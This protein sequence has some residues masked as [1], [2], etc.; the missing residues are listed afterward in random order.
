M[1]A[2]SLFGGS[3]EQ[4]LTTETKALLDE[5]LTDTVG[6]TATLTD[7]GGEA[8]L[9]IGTGANGELQGAVVS[10]SVA[11]AAEVNDGVLNVAIEL[12]AGVNFGFE[13]LGELASI[14]EAQ[15][16]FTAQLEQSL[17]ESSA[18][19]AILNHFASLEK[20][21]TT[22]FE[23]LKD[24]G[25]TNLAVRVI[26][27]IDNSGEVAGE[28]D[29]DGSSGQTIVFDGS[30]A[31]ATEALVF[32]LNDIKEGNTLSL[33]GVEN[34]ILTGNGHVVISDDTDAM[35]FGDMFDQHIVGGA[36]NDT[37]V[38]GGGND[39]LEGGS[40]ADI[41]GF[42]GLGNYTIKMDMN[43][44]LAFDFEGLDSLLDLAH[45]MTGVIET[46]EGLTVEFGP[47]S[48]TLLGVSADD[49][50]ADMVLFDIN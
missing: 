16:Y 34:A 42:N 47:A 50:T 7:L 36:G 2:E 10:G 14:D 38:G 46:A 24:K 17:P 49:I 44:K 29:G 33:I 35:V 25:A 26:K 18:D 11:V 13:G 20:A 15:A 30:D 39:T 22:L 32:Q 12:P 23:S 8:S 5:F 19:P 4:L 40:G 31:S 9:V 45:Y 41:F 28:L 43:D 21:I 6:G 27:F 3:S 1:G 48:I 37:L